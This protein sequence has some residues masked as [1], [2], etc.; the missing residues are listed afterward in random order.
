MYPIDKQDME[1]DNREG[2]V[3][4]SKLYLECIS[5]S[6]DKKDK[7]NYQKVH[8]EFV[9]NLYKENKAYLEKD[10]EK[11]F[12]AEIVKKLSKCT[13]F[14]EKLD[15]LHDMYAR[16]SYNNEMCNLDRRDL[17][18]IQKGQ[19][20]FADNYSPIEYK[21]CLATCKN[22]GKILSNDEMLNA[23]IK[24]SGKNIPVDAFRSIVE[25]SFNEHNAKLTEVREDYLSNLMK[26]EVDIFKTKYV[27]TM[28]K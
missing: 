25:N 6:K 12:N 11:N 1:K 18:K 13:S 27:N 4:Y 17:Y 22:V 24:K 5:F 3:Y 15:Y 10:V 26:Y 16:L 7:E 8:N 28:S 2:L 9:N 23:L 21:N 20:E 19:L 14:Q